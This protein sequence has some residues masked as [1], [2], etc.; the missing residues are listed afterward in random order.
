MN[1]E[2]QDTGPP[3]TRDQLSRLERH[4]GIRLPGDYLDFLL[5]FNGGRPTPSSF[6]IRGFDLAHSGDIQRFFGI[7]EHH[8]IPDIKWFI[9]TLSGRIPHGLLPIAGDGSG[10]VIC[11]LLSGANRGT[12]YFWH[13]DAEKSPPTYSNLYYIS[14]SFSDFLDSIHFEDLSAEIAKSIKPP[15]QRS[16]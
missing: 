11:L 1:F 9:R 12:V 5:R 14:D 3:L 6:P 2:M 13:H 8:E 15:P 7:S 4:I 16:S 10:N